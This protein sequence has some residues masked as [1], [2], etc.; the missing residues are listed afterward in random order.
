VRRS[1]AS[2]KQQ[3]AFITDI[4][5]SL[6]I[7][8]KYTGMVTTYGAVLRD[9]QTMLVMKRYRGSLAGKL[10]AGGKLALPTAL[11]CGQQVLRAIKS[12]H[13]HGGAALDL[14]PANLLLDDD[15]QLF[16]SDF[17][18]SALAEVTIMTQSTMASG[19]GTPAFMAPEQHDRHSFGKL[20]CKADLWAFGCV[21]ITMLTGE[22]PWKSMRPLEIMMQVAGQRRASDIPPGVPPAG[23]LL[24]R[25]FAHDPTQRI[26][27][28]EA[29]DM[30]TAILGAPTEPESEPELQEMPVEEVD[31]KF[32]V[33]PSHVRKHQFFLSHCQSSGQD[34]IGNLHM[35]LEARGADIWYDM[36]VQD[37]SAMGMEE[38]VSESQNFLIFLSYDYFGRPFCI[39]E[40]RWANK[41]GCRIIGVVEKDARHGAA[42]FAREMQLAPADLKDIFS[43]VEFIEFHRREPFQ[44]AMVD[45]IMR[46]GGVA[47]D[48]Q[49]RTENP[50][51]LSA[52][53]QHAK[54]AQQLIELR[55]QNAVEE[56]EHQEQ[57]DRE[58]M[59][60]QK[61]QERQASEQ[62]AEEDRI[63]REQKRQLK[64][65]RNRAKRQARRK[66][67]EQH[68]KKIATVLCCILCCVGAL[69]GIFWLIRNSGRDNCVRSDIADENFLS[70]HTPPCEECL[71]G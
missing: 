66:W 58:A 21:L 62:Q 42:D 3:E 8:A 65:R 7:G 31:I 15:D 69:L 41:Y 53:L 70:P 25:C 14:K 30:L 39:I 71:D 51:H 6:I 20:T 13:E 22:V 38:G 63:L 61:E 17:G 2:L 48:L 28:P 19:A 10:E 23:A 29:L 35:L 47:S 64:I 18:I 24:R 49:Q 12:L 52:Q 46:R 4:R 57:Q 34:Q 68:Y 45:E 16:L 27:A 36:Q 56:R 54:D 67:C 44:S 5:K 60:V 59:A 9:G 11:R 33:K 43:Q 1:R 26:G 37:L 32:A 50:L 55:K 40:L